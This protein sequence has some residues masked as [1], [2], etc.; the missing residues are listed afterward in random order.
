MNKI[1]TKYF[2]NIDDYEEWITNFFTDEIVVISLV[3]FHN[4]ALLL[5]YAVKKTKNE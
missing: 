3:Q 2:R 1:K 4:T 5:T